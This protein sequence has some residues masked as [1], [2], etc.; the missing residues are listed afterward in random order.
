MVLRYHRFWSTL[1]RVA[2]QT[3]LLRVMNGKAH[4]KIAGTLLFNDA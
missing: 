1:R 4:I 3:G 2:L